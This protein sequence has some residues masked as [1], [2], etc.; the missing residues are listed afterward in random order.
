MLQ[1]YDIKKEYKTAGESVQAL[2]G[3]SLCF[4]KNEFVSIL[5]ASGC[6]KT[7][8]LNIIGGLDKY[9]TGDL[10]IDGTSTRKFS[11]RDWDTYRNHS[12]GF[13][14]QSYHL[15]PHQTI[16]QNV[17]LAL[18]IAG[19]SKEERRARAIEAL[20]KVG[21]GD[22]I[23][24]KP[25]QLSG[26]QAQRVAIARA[27]IN[28]PEIVL[29][30]EPTGALDS[31]T[32]VQIMDLLKEISKDRL[33]IMVTHNPELA[34][35]YS[36]RII[37][38]LDGLVVGDS[39]P[40]DGV[41]KE[42][43]KPEADAET[44]EEVKEATKVKKSKGNKKRS[45][46]SFGMAFMLSL[47]NLL[48]KKGRTSLV[49]VAGSIGIIGVSMVLAIS[50]GVQAY[51]KDMEND[52]L[53]GYPLTVTETAIDF[54]AL[55]EF[56]ME[57]KADITRL[58]D[59]VYV[60]SLLESLMGMGK[61]LTTNNI[62]EEYIDY[63]KKMPEEYYNAL[64]FGYQFNLANNVY[65][66]FTITNGEIAPEADAS[67]NYSI[68]AIRQMYT[69]VLQKQEEYAQYASLIPSFGTFSEIP[70]NYEYILSQY[71]ILATYN[72]KTKNLTEAELKDI[73]ESKDS[74]IVVLDNNEISDITLGQF[75]YMTQEEFVN[76]AYK[77]LYENGMSG[78][79]NYNENLTKDFLDGKSFDLFFG[80]DAQIFTWY[81]NDTVY[82][83]VD[84]ADGEKFYTTD[85]TELY[86]LYDKMV[87]LDISE[88]LQEIKNGNLTLADCTPEQLEK[89]AE[90]QKL[91]EQMQQ[92]ITEITDKVVYKYNHDAKDFD[93]TG[94]IELKTKVIL[95]KKAKVSYGC[96]SSGLYYTNALT[97]HMLETSKESEI[98][99]YLEDS[100]LSYVPYNYEYTYYEDGGYHKGT[101]VEFNGQ[102]IPNTGL[103]SG[104]T[105]SGMMSMMMGAGTSSSNKITAAMLG[106]SDLPVS[107]SIYPSDFTGKDNVTDYLDGW[108]KMC[109]A[110]ESYNGV[111]LEESDIVKY[112]DTVG[113]IIGMVNTMIRMITIALVAFTALSLVVSTVM[114]GIITYVSVVERVKEIGILRS[115][116]A[117]KKDIKSLF[118]AETFIIGFASGL[119]GIVVTYLLSL[120]I[121]L[122]V[123]ALVG[124]FT[125]AALPW[126]QAI[127]MVCVSVVLT[128]ISGLIPAAAAAKKDPVVA[129]R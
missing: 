126:W 91:A 80:E 71:D 116:G 68:S 101:G 38:L 33:V 41:E 129:L 62:T 43:Q 18:M 54:D 104:A 84:K 45:S 100:T 28:D 79:E 118:I 27:L 57:T 20:E 2:K 69:S 9:T 85:T 36:T 44:V 121:N 46:M 55:M 99:K 64:Q 90:F 98:V 81:P 119:V 77:A 37:R 59:K 1:L 83:K 5:G 102:I 65:T 63:V 6:G 16:L 106:G 125:I 50:S 24:C 115:V 96:L 109:R 29:A 34:E 87:A 61:S 52:M 89:I 123:G 78:G 23:K 124:I 56:S 13:I 95:Q 25:N 105:P 51:I 4:R 128:L 72:G 30:D 11:D 111:T 76:F 103:I 107:I 40:Y 73:F 39:M 86:A 127:V 21:L 22:K 113:L 14:F 35:Q 110:G 48:S 32:S 117:R 67:G 12:I 94:S 122:I 10:V 66:D 58:K 92:C 49:A 97:K 19:V 112:T 120:I 108:N 42:E 8:L 114:V 31:K 7:T 75:G 26:G 88:L 53:S 60:D 47:K 3:V 15:I 74:M 70:D 93:K 17:E 82:S